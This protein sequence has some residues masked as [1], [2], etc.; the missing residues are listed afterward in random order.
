MYGQTRICDAHSST[1]SFGWS[2][3]FH[4]LSLAPTKHPVQMVPTVKRPC[5]AN[6][7]IPVLTFGRDKAFILLIESSLFHYHDRRGHC[8]DFSWRWMGREDEQVLFV[9]LHVIW[10]RSTSLGSLTI[11]GIVECITFGSGNSE[12]G[13]RDPERFERVTTRADVR[14]QIWSRRHSQDRFRL[15]TSRSGYTRPPR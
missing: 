3:G 7:T 4:G 14:K 2:Q 1:T 9:Y 10:F 15:L 13:K 11:A 6:Q 12:K 8:S 5:G